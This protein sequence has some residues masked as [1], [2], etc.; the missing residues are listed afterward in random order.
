MDEFTAIRE[1]KLHP[2]TYTQAD[3]QAQTHKAVAVRKYLH[4]SFKMSRRI[5]MECFMC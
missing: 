1:F 2:L 5:I 4:R 3:R